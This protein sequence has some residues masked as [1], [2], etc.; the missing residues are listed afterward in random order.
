MMLFVRKPVI[1]TARI[2]VELMS[3]D[4]ESVTVSLLRVICSLHE[5]SE[6]ERLTRKIGMGGA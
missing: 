2:H 6:E 5:Q 1:L 4:C 3:D